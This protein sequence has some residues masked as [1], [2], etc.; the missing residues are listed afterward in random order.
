[1]AHGFTGFQSI[2]VRRVWLRSSGHGGESMWERLFV[3]QWTR[4]ERLR[5]EVV[6]DS[7]PPRPHHPDGPHILKASQ[8]PRM[9]T[10]AGIQAFRAA[11]CGG[12]FT[13]KQ[14]LAVGK[15]CSFS[16]SSL[17]QS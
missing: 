14:T 17:F 7:T 2:L 6:R 15:A 8:P 12:H 1:M 10:A 13:F 4:K 16:V 11:T 5:K 3:L 9:V